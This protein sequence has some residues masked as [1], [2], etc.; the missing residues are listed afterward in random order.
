VAPENTLAAFQAALDSGADGIELD[1]CRCASGEII[2]IHDDAIDRTTN[3]SGT[4]A[5]IKLG[6]MRELDA[7]SWFHPR[8]AGERI[9]TLQEVFELVSGKLL[10][11]I[12]IKGR[13]LRGDGIEAEIAALVRH[14]GMDEK[15]ILSS[16]NPAALVRARRV[17][18]HLPRG[19]L[20]ARPYPAAAPVA[21]LRPWVRPQALHPHFSEVT[22]D[23]LARARQRG[24]RVNP[25]TVNE[26]ADLRRLAEM[27][28]DSLI[29]DHPALARQVVLALAH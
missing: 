16:F 6:S 1:V 13:A 26:E 11:N 27:G 24:Y 19:M 29:T 25:W 15:V 22:P 4:V 12:E 23:W 21:W 2:V 5:T 10:M 8:F 17:A 3:S 9:P 14:F 28:V 7:G 18:P 20:F